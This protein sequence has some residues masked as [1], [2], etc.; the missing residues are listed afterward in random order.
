MIRLASTAVVRARTIPPASN[1]E[2]SGLTCAR[3]V[4]TATAGRSGGVCGALPPHAVTRPRRTRDGMEMNF[5]S[6]S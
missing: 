3:A 2:G 1:H 4:E 5:T 6:A